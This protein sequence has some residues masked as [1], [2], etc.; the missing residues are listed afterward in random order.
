MLLGTVQVSIGGAF[1][2]LA[3]ERQK[4][5]IAKLALEKGKT[6]PTATLLGALWGESVPPSARTKPR[7]CQVA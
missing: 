3:G 1:L 7:C 6:V 2:R 5:L 4:A